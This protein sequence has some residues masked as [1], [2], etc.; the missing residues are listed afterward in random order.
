MNRLGMIVDVS[1]IT[2]DAVRQVLELSRAPVIASHSSCRHFTPGFER[3]L[4]DELIRA[5]AERG[6]TIQINFGGSFLDDAYRLAR[7]RRRADFE[8][9][10]AGQG[11]EAD[12]EHADALEDGFFRDPPLEPVDVSRVADHVDHV[13]RLVGIEHV[14]FGSDFDG[15]GETLPRGLEDVAAYPNLLRVL[16]DRGYDVGALAKVCSG[17]ILRVWREV[18]RVAAESP[19]RP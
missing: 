1:H 14:G 18:E 8:A 17:N 2:D 5:I 9:W 10:L 15:V 11:I 6:G 4:S 13:V 3:N 7:E 19:R 16:L 12:S